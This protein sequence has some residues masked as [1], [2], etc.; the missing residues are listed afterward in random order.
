M[1]LKLGWNALPY[2]HCCLRKIIVDASPKVA[3]APAPS[4]FLIVINRPTAA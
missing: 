1:H 4:H 2:P 3:A